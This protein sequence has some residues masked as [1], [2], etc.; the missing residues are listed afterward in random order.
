MKVPLTLV[1][2]KE[3]FKVVLKERDK[4]MEQKFDSMEKAV[5]KAEVAHEKR[6]EA[7]N[8][9]RGQLSDQTKTFVPRTEFDIVAKKVEKMENMK[10]GSSQ[11][12]VILVAGALLVIAFVGL[13]LK[14][15][16][17]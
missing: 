5:T 7:M 10:Q 3:H 2:L 11:A 8:E 1:S 14:F 12:W 4:R 9:F 13:A 15:L 16:M 17:N 6:L